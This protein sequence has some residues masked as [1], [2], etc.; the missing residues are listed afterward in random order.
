MINIF[1]ITVNDSSQTIPREVNMESVREKIE[2]KAYEL[3]LQRGGV[4]GYAI[5][6][7]IK[8]EKEVMSGSDKN[9]GAAAKTKKPGKK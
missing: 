9:A 1:N 4:H 2:K 8:A 6:D 3:F 5:E 7:W